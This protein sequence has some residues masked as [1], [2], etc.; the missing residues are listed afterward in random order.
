MGPT[1]ENDRPRYRPDRT[2]R[3]PANRAALSVPPILRPEGPDPESA[4][5][6]KLRAQRAQRRRKRLIKRGIFAGVAVL[7]IVGA[8]VA[9]AVVTAP[10]DVPEQTVTDFV[11]RGDFTNEVSS[12]GSV[13][14]YSSVVVTPQIDGTIDQV[15]VSAGSTVAAG[16]VLFTIKND[17]LDRAGADFLHQLG[18]GRPCQV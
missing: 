9:Y 13:E 11:M 15:M 3:I 5:L 6:A 8:G 16:D 18:N 12:A 1:F 14:P 7:A 10:P 4:A 2:A 17:A